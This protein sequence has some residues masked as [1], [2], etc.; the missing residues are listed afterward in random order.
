MPKTLTKST[1]LNLIISISAMAAFGVTNFEFNT[2]VT[3]V[4][5]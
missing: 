3:G 1:K 4:P 5:A 2:I